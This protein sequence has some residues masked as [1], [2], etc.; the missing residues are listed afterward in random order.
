MLGHEIAHALARHGAERMSQGKLAQLGGTALA[1][2]LGGSAS[3]SAMLAAYG[4]GAQCGALLPYGRTQ[5]SE[6]DHIELLL[7]AQTGY[8]PRVAIDFWERMEQT[9]RGGSPEVLSTHPSHGTR[10]TKLR[11]WI[12][13]AMR[14]YAGTAPAPDAPLARDGNVKR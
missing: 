13:E 3:S 12:P 5:D 1:I 10:I 4:L 2:G 8:D 9:S 7:M 14:A 6:A 11:A